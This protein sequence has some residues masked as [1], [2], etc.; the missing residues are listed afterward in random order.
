M[1]NHDLLDME[2]TSQISAIQR[3][4]VAIREQD[5]LE[6]RGPSAG[7]LATKNAAGRRSSWSARSG[8][9]SAINGALARDVASLWSCR[10]TRRS[11]S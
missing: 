10:R 4:S 1:P 8:I 6:V 3:V 2:R 5:A 9:A 11:Y 7:R